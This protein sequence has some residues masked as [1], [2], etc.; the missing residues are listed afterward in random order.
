M[1]AGNLLYFAHAQS[2]WPI[3][4]R[5]AFQVPPFPEADP[6]REGRTL[7]SY[8]GNLVKGPSPIRVGGIGGVKLNREAGP[9]SSFYSETFRT[10]KIGDLISVSF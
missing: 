7:T 1:I 10:F 2:R 8:K 3:R 9:V 6:R 5:I 4:Y